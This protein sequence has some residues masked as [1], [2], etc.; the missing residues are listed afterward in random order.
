MDGEAFIK[1][2]KDI[3]EF[4]GQIVIGR[5]EVARHSLRD[6]IEDTENRQWGEN[7]GKLWEAV[8][9]DDPELIRRELQSGRDGKCKNFFGLS[10][11]HWALS[12]KHYRSAS[13][14]VMY[15]EL[16][17]IVIDDIDG[18]PIRCNCLVYLIMDEHHQKKQDEDK[19]IEQEKRDLAEMMLGNGAS[20]PL[21]FALKDFE[22]W[23][24]VPNWMVE[25]FL[26]EESKEKIL[27]QNID[28]SIQE[29]I[30]LKDLGVLQKNI[31]VSSSR[32]NWQSYLCSCLAGDFLEGLLLLVKADE[33]GALT[34]LFRADETCE[35][36]ILG[37]YLTLPN[38]S[39][40][41][42]GF[43]LYLGV[44]PSDTCYKENRG[45]EVGSKS[46]NAVEFCKVRHFSQLLSFFDESESSFSDIIVPKEVQSLIFKAQK[47]Q[48]GAISLTK[49]ELKVLLRDKWKNR[50]LKKFAKVT[51]KKADLAQRVDILYPE[52][53]SSSLFLQGRDEIRTTEHEFCVV[54]MNRKVSHAVIPCGHLCLCDNEKCHMVQGKCPFCG[55]K[56]ASICRI[57]LQGTHL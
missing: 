31:S 44:S 27:G 13:E 56:S 37:W 22:S 57:H 29:S 46:Y 33:T 4:H 5:N 39:L 43:L 17:R 30:V 15:S 23:M 9:D 50:E 36:S 47:S 7:C 20:L 32:E 34:R 51:G 53:A 8:C 54:C 6:S 48:K 16:N 14:L 28:K 1:Q 35:F 45:L 38:C 49:S 3:A 10:P 55:V 41:T 24:K 21:V 11:I 12:K 52:I 40:D 26:R 2:D 18:R 19:D 25:L 42:I